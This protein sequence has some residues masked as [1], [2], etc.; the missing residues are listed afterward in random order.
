MHIKQHEIDRI[1]LDNL[2]RLLRTLHCQGLEVGLK[3]DLQRF[4]K[5]AIIVGNQDAVITAKRSPLHA[6]GNTETVWSCSDYQSYADSVNWNVAGKR[7]ASR[8]TG[9]LVDSR[10][11][12]FG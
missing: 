7:L 12:S 4:P 10:G 5:A 11:R 1:V 6:R 2:N 3:N 9:E 8:S